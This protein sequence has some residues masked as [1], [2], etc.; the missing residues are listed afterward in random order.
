MLIYFGFTVNVNLLTFCFLFWCIVGFVEMFLFNSNLAFNYIILYAQLCSTYFVSCPFFI[1]RGSY[2][3]IKWRNRRRTPLSRSRW[4]QDTTKMLL[5]KFLFGQI[6]KMIY[7]FR[8]SLLTGSIFF[9]VFINFCFVL[10]VNCL[11]ICILFRCSV[12]FVKVLLFI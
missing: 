2:W 7:S 5:L 3:W 12:V 1:N 11:T 6:S 4:W 9:I 10:N 8:E